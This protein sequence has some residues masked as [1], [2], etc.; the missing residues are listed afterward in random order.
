MPP[1]VAACHAQRQRAAECE[2][3]FAVLAHPRAAPMA[4][5]TSINVVAVLKSTS[6]SAGGDHEPR[7]QRNGPS[8]WRAVGARCAMQAPTSTHAA[9]MAPIN[10]T[11]S[12]RRRARPLL[13]RSRPIMRAASGKS[14]VAEIGI[15]LSPTR[16]PSAARATQAA[17]LWRKPS[18]GAGIGGPAQWPAQARGPPNG[19]RGQSRYPPRRW[20]PR[21]W[22]PGAAFLPRRLFAKA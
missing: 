18:G 11:R 17:R 19:P 12:D 4:M 13:D 7:H 2:I 10:K 3:G 14:A 5:G 9:R 16:S 8:A 20:S 6:R 15:P 21:S 1:M 22:L